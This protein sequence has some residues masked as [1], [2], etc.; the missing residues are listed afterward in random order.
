[1][2]FIKLDKKVLGIL[3]VILVVVLTGAFF[4]YKYLS[5]PTPT[6]EDL[7]GGTFNSAGEE[8]KSDNLPDIQIKTDQP[9]DNGFSVCSDQCGNG[10]CQKEDLSCDKKS[11]NCVCAENSQDCPQDCK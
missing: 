11:L 3:A 7:T 9:I 6:P 5:N 4:G 8:E 10:V 1:M 2:Q